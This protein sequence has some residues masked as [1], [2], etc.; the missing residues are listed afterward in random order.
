MVFSASFRIPRTRA[1]CAGPIAESSARMRDGWEC[2]LSLLR[3]PCRLKGCP[4][5]ATVAP[6]FSLRLNTAEN[7]RVSSQ[8]NLQP[9][10]SYTSAA[11][12]YRQITFQ[13][14]VSCYAE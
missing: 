12:R 11:A 13:V 1:Y 5:M 7:S 8:E 10:N 9:G 4:R 14:R 6:P 3:T 2:D